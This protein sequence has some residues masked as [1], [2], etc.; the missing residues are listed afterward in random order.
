MRNLTAALELLERTPSSPERDRREFA[1]QTSLG[2]ALM[3]TKGWAAPE[4]ER[5]YLRAERLA[6]TGATPEQQFALLVGLFGLLYVGG[7]LSGARE[8]QK[9]IWDF[10][11]RH[12]DPVFLLEAIHHDWSVALSAGELEASQRHVERGLKLFESKLRSAAVPLYTAH[13]P[14]VCGYAWDAQIS[15]LRGRPDAARRSAERAV[16]LANELGD[17]MSAAFALYEKALVHRMMLEPKLALE[18]A[19]AAIDTAEDVGFLYVLRHARVVKGWALTEL[20]R[21]EEGIGQI[22]E[23]TDAL[24]A[25]REEL[26][27]TLCLATLADACLRAG[28]IEHGLKAIGDALDLVRRSGE[29]FWEAEINRL[30]GELLL[31]Q[32]DSNAAGAR[33]CFE[34]AIQLARKQDAKSLELRATASLARLLAKQGNGAAARAM[35]ADIYNW[36]TEGFDTADLKDAKALLDE[37][38]A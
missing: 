12:P 4:T 26:W 3:A 8:R 34:R 22:R 25:N 35:L 17:A 9:P 20:G 18:I 37:L 28:R 30:R 2:P 33:S 7:N 6:E 32:S 27:L 5:A 24:S 13:H 23:E 10:V 38:S 19:G 15:W 36:F 1:L 29:C 31:R 11:D 14:A 16:S 21:A